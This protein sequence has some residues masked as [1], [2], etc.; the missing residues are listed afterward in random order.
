MEHK[1]GI[2]NT[3]QK[4]KLEI[5][6]DL[7]KICH[8]AS[9]VDCK[10]DQQRCMQTKSRNFFNPSNLCSNC[11]VDRYSSFSHNF[12]MTGFHFDSLIIIT[13]TRDNKR[14]FAVLWRFAISGSTV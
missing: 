6:R 8:H 4:R 5:C 3:I 11:T 12:V 2:K 1:P 13:N 14:I 10:T 9:E 7:T